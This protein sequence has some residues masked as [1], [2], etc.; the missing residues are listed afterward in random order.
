MA[1]RGDCEAPHGFFAGRRRLELDLVDHDGGAGL[2]DY[3]NVPS[4]VGLLIS[5]EAPRVTLA[6]LQTI[7]G[8]EDLYDMLEVYLVNANNAQVM[9]KRRERK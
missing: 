8:T 1:T 3:R 2:A 6:E 7:Y 5:V 9:A 4:L